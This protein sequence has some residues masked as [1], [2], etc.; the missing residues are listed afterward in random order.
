VIDGQRLLRFDG[1]TATAVLDLPGDRPFIHAVPIARDDVFVLSGGGDAFHHDG[2]RW[3][4]VA[5]MLGGI[6]ATAGTPGQLFL[7]R[8]TWLTT[9]SRT[10]RWWPRSCER[11]R[12][13]GVDDDGDGAIDEVDPCTAGGAP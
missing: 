6:V 10:T 7:L 8:G 13:D 3:S 4:R 9:L 2:Q 12:H 5:R 11:D 1:V